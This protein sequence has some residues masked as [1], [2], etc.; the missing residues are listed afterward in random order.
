M[1]SAELIRKT[2]VQNSSEQLEKLGDP[3]D[4][5]VVVVGLIDEAIHMY[6][7]RSLISSTEIVN[8]LL[9]IRTGITRTE[10]TV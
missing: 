2:R 10:E 9:D 6:S 8:L 4:D 1:C 5:R 3:G 7:L